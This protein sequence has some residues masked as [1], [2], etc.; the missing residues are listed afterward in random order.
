[1]ESHDLIMPEFTEQDYI[2]T[3]E[4]YKWL[5]QFSDDKFLLQQKLQQ[6]QRAA[7]A[8]G[9]RCFMSL[10]KA[11][12]ESTQQKKGVKL[13][14]ATAFEGQP[15][16]L[17]SGQYICD[18]Y[19]VR[20]IDRFGYEVPICVHPIMPVRRLINIDE[21]EERLEIAYRKGRTWRTIIVQKSIIASSQKIL[22]LAAYGIV[23]TS[24]NAKMLSSYL[25]TLEQLNYENMAEQ[26]SVGR[27][28]WV[29]DNVFSPYVED[30][31]FDGEANFKHMFAA[32]KA[33]GSREKWIEAMKKIRAEKSV[34]RIFLAA[35]F[36]SALIEPCG[37]LPFFVHAY[38]GQGTGKTVSLMVAASVWASPK[39]G[40]YLV[41]FNSTDVGQ[42]MVASFLNSMP[43]CM[44][45]LQ[46]QAASGSHEFDRMLYKLTQGIGR[47]RGSKTGGIRRTVT[48]RNCILTTGEFPI[49][50]PNSMG[51][52]TVRAIEVECP[53]KIYSDLVGL[54]AVINENYGWAG[55]EFVEYIRDPDNL[56]M[57]NAIRMDIYHDLQKEGEDKQAASLSAILAADLI[58]SDLFFNDGM[59]LTAEELI[60]L[61]TKKK[62]IDANARALTWI[63]EMVAINR[64][65]FVP[66][67]Y[68][69]WRSEVWG[70]WDDKNIYIIKAV[71][72]RQMQDA[73][74]NSTS[75]LGWAKRK[76]IILTDKNRRTKNFL[77]AGSV[78]PCVCLDRAACRALSEE[79]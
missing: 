8:A 2:E 1:M 51:G 9:V 21:G 57:V 78:I 69:N 32:V 54:C 38:G 35:S 4:P 24:E 74:F 10:W 33:V 23:V 39:M 27:L 46:I 53:E 42:E 31:T 67:E 17:F 40:D 59:Q 50:N 37:I 16:E 45:E 20:I 60:S 29:L 65:H 79:D 68:G 36:A 72:D 52:A 48:W 66:D 64:N 22:D 26:H 77:V 63:Q 15:V 14:N 58:A 11:Y 43:L 13:D 30:L 6:M 62:D 7:G 56:S 5:D 49:I 19:G 28:G 55:R 25:L 47:V 61:M 73:G 34:A 12:K 44:D 3:S 71:F 76:G 18:D 75:F 70:R 41:S